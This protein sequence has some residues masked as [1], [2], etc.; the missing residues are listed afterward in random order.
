MT[1]LTSLRLRALGSTLLSINGSFRI[2]TFFPSHYLELSGPVEQPDQQLSKAEVGTGLPTI[3]VVYIYF[4]VAVGLLIVDPNG[5]HSTLLGVHDNVYIHYAGSS[6][7]PR[8]DT[9]PILSRRLSS[10]I[11]LT[12]SHKPNGAPSGNQAHAAR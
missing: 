11:G 8:L 3:N 12:P 10:H 2:S 7:F 9:S 4:S 1:I 6:E 5:S